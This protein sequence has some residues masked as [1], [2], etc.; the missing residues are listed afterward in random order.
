MKKRTTTAAALLSL[1]VA[2]ALVA[3]HTPTHREALDL[4]GVQKN[5]P[6][7]P[8][9]GEVPEPDEAEN[10]RIIEEATLDRL[11][12]DH[13]SSPVPRDVHQKGHGCLRA[14]FDVEPNLNPVLQTRLFRPGQ[15]YPAWVRFS[16]AGPSMSA[17]HKQDM[18]GM[19]IKLMDVPGE[20]LI[21]DEKSLQTQDFLL[22]NTPAFFVRNLKEYA[23]VLTAIRRGTLATVAWF[24]THPHARRALQIG[25]R[26]PIDN[27]LHERFFSMTPYR[28][29]DRVVKYVVK[30]CEAFPPATQ[31]PKEDPDALRHAMQESLK[32]KD[33]CFAFYVQ[34]KPHHSALPVEDSTVP[35]E[36]KDAPLVKVATIHIPQQT[37]DTAKVDA[38]CEGLS[39]TPWHA[40]PE[41]RPLGSLNR[42][43]LRVY[44]VIARF[45]NAQ[46][47]VA[48]QE[49]TG[50]SCEGVLG[51]A[52]PKA[53]P[54]GPASR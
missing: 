10:M 35:W 33:A 43:R 39:F 3:C 2:A 31:T 20:K 4:P 9:L 13:P 38:F 27:P 45:R 37:F 47:G 54:A 19:A 5:P 8:A 26:R 48:H 14:F 1:W 41:H 24:A 15:R 34:P 50:H 12:K 44:E 52:C 30:P 40:L 7:D 28:L 6:I 53:P 32:V 17:D 46:N 11:L 23:G 21:N 16:N 36:E 49:P 42:S 22:I 51:K 29:N 18:R 25:L